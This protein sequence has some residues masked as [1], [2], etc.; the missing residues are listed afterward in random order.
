MFDT[1]NRTPFPSIHH[2][3]VVYD[4]WFNSLHTT[5]HGG[6]ADQGRRSHLQGR[7]AGAGALCF[8]RDCL[9]RAHYMFRLLINQTRWVQTVFLWYYFMIQCFILSVVGLADDYFLSCLLEIRRW[10]R[11]RRSCASA[12][13]RYVSFPVLMRICCSVVTPALWNSWW[14]ALCYVLLIVL[15]GVWYNCW[16]SNNILHTYVIL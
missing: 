11:L 4:T 5:G 15:K 14:L 13:C 6:E 9:H 1:R 8:Y 12:R 3:Y 16:G 10:E 2:Y 7:P